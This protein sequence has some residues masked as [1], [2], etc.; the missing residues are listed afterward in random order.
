MFC[1]VQSAQ[2]LL[3]YHNV[4]Q[5]C[6]FG[7]SIPKCKAWLKE[8]DVDLYQKLYG[9][10][11]EATGEEAQETEQEEQKPKKKKPVATKKVVITTIERTK[12]K[13]ITQIRGLELFGSED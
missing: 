2:F 10:V 3:K 11:I 9:E 5:Y 13:R 8:T 7:S 6:E 4:D 12:R 1:T